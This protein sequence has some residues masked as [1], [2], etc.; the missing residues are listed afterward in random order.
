VTEKTALESLRRAGERREAA[1]QERFEATV[2]LRKA[3][4]AAHKAGVG[5][6][7]I[8]QETGLSRQAVYEILGQQPS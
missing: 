3:V 8:A 4:Q 7:R 1:D 6:T 2:E 5:P